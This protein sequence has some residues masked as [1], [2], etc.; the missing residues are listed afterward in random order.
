[1]PQDATG[2]PVWLISV[3]RLL[4]TGLDNIRMHL[5]D[6]VGLNDSLINHVAFTPTRAGALSE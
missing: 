5:D 2:A 4:T 3:V 6:A 1:M